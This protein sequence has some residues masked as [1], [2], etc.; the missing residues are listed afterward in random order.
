MLAKAGK[1]HTMLNRL[2]PTSFNAR[3]RISCHQSS[4]SLSNEFLPE[5]TQKTYGLTPQSTWPKQNTISDGH[6]LQIFKF[7]LPVG[8][9]IS[10]KYL[11][12]VNIIRKLGNGYKYAHPPVSPTPY[13]QS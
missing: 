3:E 6:I 4:D 13:L 7:Y 9:L 1:R 8:Y 2:V 12:S 5:A 11:Q 10:D